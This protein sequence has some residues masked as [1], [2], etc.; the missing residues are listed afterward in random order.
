MS[1]LPNQLKVNFPFFKLNTCNLNFDFIS[2]AK[3]L[4]TRLANQT[5]TR[6][7]IDKKVISKLA[8]MQHAINVQI[9]QGN[10]QPEFSY[11]T[12][13]TVEFFT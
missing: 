9:F 3:N 11:S 4:A 13:Y 12:D 2:Q 5:L 6:L 7:V 10:E 8:D 1:K